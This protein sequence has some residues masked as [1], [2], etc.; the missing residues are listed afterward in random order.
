MQIF[1][2]I[3]HPFIVKKMWQ[4]GK[5]YQLFFLSRPYF[6][7]YSPPFPR[8]FVNAWYYFIRN[9]PSPGTYIYVF[10]QHEFM[11]VLLT[12]YILHVSITLVH[13]SDKRSQASF[14]KYACVYKVYI[15]ACIHVKEYVYGYSDK[16]YRQ[17]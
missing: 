11:G 5:F 15:H 12:Y 4:I 16:T 6:L 8:P 1:R 17:V 2:I 9:C 7:S 14:G 3:L 13:F 10:K